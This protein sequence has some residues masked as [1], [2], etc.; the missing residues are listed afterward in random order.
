MRNCGHLKRNFALTPSAFLTGRSSILKELF[1][2]ADLRKK[3]SVYLVVR[4]SIINF[5]VAFL[6]FM[7]SESNLSKAVFLGTLI[8]ANALFLLSLTLLHRME[9]VKAFLYAHFIFDVFLIT[10]LSFFDGGVVDSDLPLL[11]Y[12]IILAAGVFFYDRGAVLIAT[13]VSIFY[14]TSF[15]LLLTEQ[16]PVHDVTGILINPAET[17][18]MAF[19]TLFINLVLF[20]IV[21]YVISNLGMAYLKKGEEFE[22]QQILLDDIFENV[23]FSLYVFDHQ[24]LLS[25]WNSLG[26][27]F[28]GK[29]LK[30][31]L[32]CSQVLP[33]EIAIAL[34]KVYQ[35]HIENYGDD[36]KRGQQYFNVQISAI[37]KND[38]DIGYMVL[39]HDITSKKALEEKLQEMDRLAYLGTL[40]AGMAHELRNPLASL[41]GSIQLLD[42]RPFNEKDKHLYGLI[43][44]EAE[45]LN[46]IVTDFLDF[47]KGEQVEKKTVPIKE[48][49]R[50]VILMLSVLTGK[51]IRLA[52][53]DLFVVGDKDLLIQT[54]NNLIW[55]AVEASEKVKRP[56]EVNIMN[57]GSECCVEV[58]DYGV[59]ME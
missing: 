19:L 12:L 31:G 49:I 57:Q 10:A 37:R 54:F 46:K 28:S 51:E 55:N 33:N 21:S 20:Y 29:R 22:V 1:M 36:F 58:R 40:G 42:E 26:E 41:Y 45:R 24:G 30:L 39:V 9:K 56:V 11:F 13:I 5:V 6:F 4:I 50:E 47:V 25:R 59:G 52:G 3:T 34:K 15:V 17:Q 43:L 7:S 53:D 44:R 27:S 48:L 8:V 2:N 18:E 32:P 16:I 14:I 35:Q 23:T 38:N